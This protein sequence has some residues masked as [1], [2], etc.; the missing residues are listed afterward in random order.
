MLR[1]TY[2]APRVKRRSPAPKT[3]WNFNRT[4]C[5]RV[6]VSI[7]PSRSRETLWARKDALVGTKRAAVQV[8]PDGLAGEP[9][10]LDDID[11]AGWALVT[12]HRG[13][14]RIPH[15]MLDAAEVLKDLTEY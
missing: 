8:W 2:P 12:R 5:F 7:G 4:P 10:Y 1:V 14:A 13:D 15:R 6:I 9:L 3:F 11:G